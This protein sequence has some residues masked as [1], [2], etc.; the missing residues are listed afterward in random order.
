M[1]SGQKGFSQARHR[2]RTCCHRLFGT[3]P[4]F[5]HRYHARCHVL[6][7][8]PVKVDRGKPRRFCDDTVCPDPVWKLSNFSTRVVRAYPLIET[9]QTVPG[10]AIRGKCVS[11]NGTLPPLKTIGWTNID[12]CTYMYTHMYPYMYTYMCIHIYIYIYTQSTYIHI[13]IY[14]YT[15]MYT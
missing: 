10:R 1:G 6:L 7:D 15:Y 3:V 11:I 13:Y 4:A 2:S 5:C 9:R 14:I 12:V 8:F